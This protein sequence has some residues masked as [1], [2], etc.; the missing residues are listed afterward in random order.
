MYKG[1]SFN[2]AILSGFDLT[3][4]LLH[5]LLRFRIHPIAVIGDIEEM[6]LQVRVPEADRDALRLLWWS[7]DELKGEPDIYR[8]TV[9]PFDVTSSP[10]GA[11]FVL[12]KAIERFG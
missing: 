7:N 8:F 9:H 5:A 2:D 1:V 3:N 4:P 11:N 12:R 10:F 6:F